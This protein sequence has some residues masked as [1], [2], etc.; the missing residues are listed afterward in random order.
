MQR[1]PEMFYSGQR[2]WPGS[3]RL[4]TVPTP[5]R[6]STPATLKKLEKL[7]DELDAAKD[8]SEATTKE[9]QHARRTTQR[10]K[11][12][13]RLQLHADHTELKRKRSEGGKTGD[14][15]SK[16][17]VELGQKGGAARARTLSPKQRS[18]LAKKAAKSRWSSV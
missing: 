11:H 12:D 5:Q 8:A 16:A 17:A 18:A 4:W 7:T 15:K 14:G 1:I 13:L 6:Q 9:V 3:A 2:D 10:V